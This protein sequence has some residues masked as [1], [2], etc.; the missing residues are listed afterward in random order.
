MKSNLFS[1]H[2]KL[3]R[4]IPLVIIAVAL[5]MTIFGAGMNLGIDF[6]G[7]SLFTYKVGEDFDVSVVE[8]AL[9]IALCEL[10]MDDSAHNA[11]SA[12][13]A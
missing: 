9:A 1:G 3:L 4:A 5:V 12:H 8:S 13:N 6:T 2:N 10:M 7:G 11:L